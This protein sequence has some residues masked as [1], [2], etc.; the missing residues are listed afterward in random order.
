MEAA[1]RGVFL[2]GGRLTPST[3]A[4]EEP[5]I[6]IIIIRPQAYMKVEREEENSQP[7][8][9][10]FKT[11]VFLFSRDTFMCMLFSYSLSLTVVS[12]G[13]HVLAFGNRENFR[14]R[15][16]ERENNM[17]G[18]TKRPSLLPHGSNLPWA[19]Q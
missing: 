3:P 11:A 7:K 15:E 5:K 19:R 8:V 16:K 1:T 12:L 9:E 17:P 2:A 18:G 14:G 4:G 10:V 6:I 13:R